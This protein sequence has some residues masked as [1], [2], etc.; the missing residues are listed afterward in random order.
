MVLAAYTLT[1]LLAS[2]V[3][4]GESRLS[5]LTGTLWVTKERDNTVAKVEAATGRVLALISVGKNPV[6]LVAPKGTAKVYV[7]NEFDSTISVIDKATATVTK[8]ISV[9]S[10]PHH[11]HRSPDGK[12]VYVALFGADK[13]AVIS[14]ANDT[15]VGEYATGRPGARPRTPRASSDG[16][17]L[18]VTNFN[19]GEIVELNAVTGKILRTIKVGRGSSEVLVTKDGKTA[20]V[21]PR[22]GNELQI[23][24]LASNT[25]VREIDLGSI[26]GT[27][28]LTRDGA[29]MV[30]GLR[31]SPAKAA[32]VDMK[33]LTVKWV[34]LPGFT[35]GHNAVSG[36][37]RFAFIAVEGLSKGPPDPGV[38]V[39]DLRSL[40]VAAF[41]R[42]PGWGKPHGL[43]FEPSDDGD[44][45]D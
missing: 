19:M 21:S 39:V 6:D 29:I 23:I 28:S 20:Y 40:S 7:S 27:L 10:S 30:I 24:D 16:K 45:S 37:G 13:V 14:T 33:S 31:D 32:V 43:I 11:M 38:V 35:T 5:G 42:Y 12:F 25:I 22:Y 17:T 26:P 2:S 44:T 41:Y 18:W 4:A 15:L 34:D 36:D 9:G 8:K 1:I 3:L